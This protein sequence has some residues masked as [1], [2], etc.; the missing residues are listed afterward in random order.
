M[1]QQTR[2]PTMKSVSPLPPLVKLHARLNKTSLPG[3]TMRAIARS[4]P[5]RG[6]APP[7]VRRNIRCAGALDVDCGGSPRAGRPQHGAPV[8]RLFQLSRQRNAVDQNHGVDLEPARILVRRASLI[9][10]LSDEI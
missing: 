5:R 2:Q 8:S 10:V 4:G 6:A 3:K 7:C 9:A 1:K